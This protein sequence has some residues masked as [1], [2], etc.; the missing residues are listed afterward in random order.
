MLLLALTGLET[1]ISMGD[2]F[3]L[4]FIAAALIIALTGVIG[5]TSLSIV[6]Q[7]Y[8]QVTFQ[9]AESG[10]TLLVG[11]Y[12]SVILWSVGRS[13]I[14]NNSKLLVFNRH[15]STTSACLIRFSL[16]QEHQLFNMLTA[17]VSR[18]KFV[19]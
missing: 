9:A 1:K 8:A 5:K 11:R 3:L 2:G 12:G 18:L 10:S 7:S 16:A 17:Y 4:A 15:G 14:F 19:H 6:L 13:A